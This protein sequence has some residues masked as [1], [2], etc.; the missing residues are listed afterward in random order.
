MDL[1]CRALHSICWESFVA[2][3]SVLT[4]NPT[5]VVAVKASVVT[6]ESCCQQVFLATITFVS[7]RQI[8]KRIFHSKQDIS[9]L[10]FDAYLVS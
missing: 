9:N 1:F 7:V 8:A 6:C 4:A 2:L 3:L 5:A 10:L